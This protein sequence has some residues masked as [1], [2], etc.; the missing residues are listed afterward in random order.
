MGFERNTGVCLVGESGNCGGKGTEGSGKGSWFG[1]GGPSEVSVREAERWK[2]RLGQ[3]RKGLEH[4]TKE[5]A[6][7][8]MYLGTILRA[9]RVGVL[10]FKE[11][12]R[13]L[14]NA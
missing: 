12:R 5:P 10:S 3:S 4:H 7:I 14:G 1:G 9:P 11:K 13:N 8:R 6:A 2:G